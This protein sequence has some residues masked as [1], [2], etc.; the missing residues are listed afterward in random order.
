MTV[1]LG[2]IVGAAWT[3]PEGDEGDDY[4]KEGDEHVDKELA[5]TSTGDKGMSRVSRRRIVLVR[6]RSSPVRTCREGARRL[7]VRCVSVPAWQSTNR[8]GAFRPGPDVRRRSYWWPGLGER[9]RMRCRELVWEAA[10]RDRQEGGEGGR[11]RKAEWV[12]LRLFVVLRGR[13]SSLRIQD[14]TENGWDENGGHWDQ[15]DE[16]PMRLVESRLVVMGSRT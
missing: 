13:G 2:D 10:S 9:G 16:G 12:S 11:K 15:G 8:M 1:V 5:K 6:W 14:G 3:A 7:K 4:V